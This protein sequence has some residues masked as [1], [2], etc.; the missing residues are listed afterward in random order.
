MPCSTYKLKM[1]NNFLFFVLIKRNCAV[2]SDKRAGNTAT[3]GIFVAPSSGDKIN[4]TSPQ[5][6]SA[7]QN[8]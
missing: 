3:V 2:R 4:Q 5:T 6:V 1:K 8:E 7:T